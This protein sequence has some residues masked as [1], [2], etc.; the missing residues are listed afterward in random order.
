MS[1]PTPARHPRLA[2]VVLQL[3]LA[4][5]AC[6]QAPAG[7]AEQLAPFITTATRVPVSFAQ[8]ASASGVVTAADLAARQQYD[9]LSA[10]G[11]QPGLP[12]ATTGQTGGVTSLFARGSNS[13]HT[14]VLIDGI[15]FNDANTEYFNIIGGAMLGAQERVEIVRGPQSSLYGGEAL[16]GVIALRQDRGSGAGSGALSVE[17]GSFGTTDAILSAQGQS[18]D[19]AYAFN[20]AAGHTDNDRPDNTFTHANFALRLDRDLNPSASLGATVR[21]Y[22]GRYESPGDRFTN[23]PNNTDREQIMLATV[24]TD[25]R[26]AADWNIH[27]ILG[28][29]YRKLVSDNP[30]PNPPYATPP[31][32][33]YN[34]TKRI[35]FDGQSTW[36][37][38]A[39]HRVTFGTTADHS[40]T[41]NT[42]FG[43]I[44]RSESLVA[45]FAQ[46]EVK[47]ADDLFLTVG[48]RNDDYGT[49]G[50]A[51]TGRAAVAW[52][53]V[54]RQLKFRA[55]YGT[56]FRPPSFL[57]LYGTSAYY[58]GNPTLGPEKAKGWDAGFDLTLPGKQGL[59]AVTFFDSRY[60]NLI[61]YDFMVFPATVRNVGRARTHGLETSLQLNLAS[62][63]RF[64]LAHTWLEATNDITGQRLLRRPR[65][66]VGADLRQEIGS[67]F[68][69]GAGV[70]V[71]LDREDVDA[72]T[73]MTVNG[74]NFTVARIYAAWRVRPDLDVRVRLENALGEKYEAVNGFPS[75]GRAGYVGLDWRF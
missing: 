71:V 10:L 69:L 68:T 61:D 43:N 45:F 5:V 23:D 6:A 4:A 35:V 57:D 3:G 30:L 11:T 2:L 22:Q 14:L 37:G 29:Q 17:G 13:N 36:T 39:G 63:T 66:Q 18:G 56:A 25:L 41:R 52:N 1:V 24:F 55:S 47:L 32:N 62:H 42:G 72:A 19:A 48:L 58:V 27:L 75:P 34:Q 28:G 20:L 8:L 53:A 44:D 65:N 31:S 74:E 54:P 15:R 50:N 70:T 73:Y 67:A 21:G 26:P 7:P 49:F 9:L 12:Y 33:T 60:D 40:A 16:G 46:D 51:A 59:L 38:L 64:E